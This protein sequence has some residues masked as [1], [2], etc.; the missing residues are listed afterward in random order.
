MIGTVSALR[1]RGVDIWMS[2][3]SEVVGKKLPLGFTILSSSMV[4]DVTRVEPD[5]LP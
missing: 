5:G 4:L 1:P 3:L 2:R